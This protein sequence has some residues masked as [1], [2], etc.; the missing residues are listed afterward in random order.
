MVEA[1]LIL[2]ERMEA[3]LL[4]EAR[5]RQVAISRQGQQILGRLQKT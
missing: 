5:G 4:L 2:V 3:G 1:I